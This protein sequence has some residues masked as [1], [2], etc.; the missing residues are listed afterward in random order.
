MKGLGCQRGSRC[1]FAHGEHELRTEQE[2]LPNSYIESVNN[3][4]T[5]YLSNAYCNYKTV[6][7]N[8]WENGMPCKFGS[9]CTYAHGEDEMRSPYDPMDKSSVQSN[10]TASMAMMNAMML[11]P[12]PKAALGILDKLPGHH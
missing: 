5:H 12:S 7:C 8:M 6:M 3:Q 9:N 11:Q 1:H 2:P 4:R 10:S